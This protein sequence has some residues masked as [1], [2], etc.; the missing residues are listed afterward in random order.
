MQK[1]LSVSVDT[2]LHKVVRIYAAHT[3]QSMNE[4]VV[5]ALQAY[6]QECPKCGYKSTELE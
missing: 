4:V 1:R 5:K 3:D 6:L 2:D